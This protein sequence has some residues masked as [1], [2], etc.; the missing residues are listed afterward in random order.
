[1]LWGIMGRE[2]WR[3]DREDQGDGEDREDGDYG[4]YG[5]DGEAVEWEPGEGKGSQGRRRWRDWNLRAT[6]DLGIYI[7]GDT[8]DFL[9]SLWLYYE[10]KLLYAVDIYPEF[11]TILIAIESQYI[12]YYHGALKCLIIIPRA[13]RRYI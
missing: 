11:L 4:E 12:S 8:L 3:K 5:E 7:L 9:E 2:G 6:N 1:M 13:Y 10:G